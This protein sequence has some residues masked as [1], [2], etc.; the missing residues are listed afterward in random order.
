MEIG[1]NK[2]RLHFVPSSIPEFCRKHVTDPHGWNSL[3]KL[4]AKGEENAGFRPEYVD[5]LFFMDFIM[6]PV[7]MVIYDNINSKKKTYAG[8]TGR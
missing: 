1:F 8:S 2:G 4:V 7:L 5:M 3:E 6:M